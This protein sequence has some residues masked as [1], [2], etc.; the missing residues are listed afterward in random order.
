MSNNVNKVLVV[1]TGY[2]AREYLKVLN[3]LNLDY[4]VV[5][6]RQESVDKLE[7]EQGISAIPGGIDNYLNTTEDK[8][9]PTYAIVAVTTYRL[10]DV[11]RSLVLAGVKNILVEK[12]G[13]E[14]IKQAEEL[15]EHAKAKGVNIYIAYNRR[16]YTS[17]QE[18]LR[19]SEEDGGIESINFEFTEWRQS[20]EA[21]SH[22][23]NIKQKWFLMNSSHVVDLA[24]FLSGFPKEIQTSIK[25]SLP[26]HSSGCIYGGCGLTDRG[27]VFT[28]QA[29]W[30]SPGRW[31]IEAL[32]KKHRLY[33]RPMEK[34]AIQEKYS[35][36]IEECK[37]EDQ[38]DVDYKAGLMEEVRAFL[39]LNDRQD[40]LCTLNEQMSILPVFSKI[41]GE[42]Y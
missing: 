26:W 41:S 22:P 15:I 29:N 28:Y 8:N 27:I 1:G 7:S 34:L 30:D 33:L 14:S 35:V 36:S 31:G 16:F 2:M 10:Y 11:T 25:G 5:G 42:V 4:E 23:D 18:L 21:T 17:V 38:I 6:N 20:I 37:L 13:V 32:T 39:E 19:I 12:P 3:G 24:F 9:I 40:D